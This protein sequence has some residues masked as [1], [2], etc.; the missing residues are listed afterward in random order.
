MN[1]HKMDLETCLNYNINKYGV[2]YN[3]K[4]NFRMLKVIKNRLSRDNVGIGLL[5]LPKS[6][7]FKELPKPEDMNLDWL[8]ENLK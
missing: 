6:G 5:F 3:L 8:N 7:S 4:D 1:A 2:P